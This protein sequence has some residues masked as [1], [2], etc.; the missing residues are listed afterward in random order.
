MLNII[1]GD[2]IKTDDNQSIEVN[3]KE[4][5]LVQSVLK[6]LKNLNK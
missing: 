1:K 6:S 4:S 2:L 5:C 3:L